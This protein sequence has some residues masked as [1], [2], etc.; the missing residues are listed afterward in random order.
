MTALITSSFLKIFLGECNSL[1]SAHCEQN[2]VEFM[3]VHFSL[4]HLD[5]RA[6]ILTCDDYFELRRMPVL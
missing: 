3:I 5:V 1:S 2:T 4:K 6:E